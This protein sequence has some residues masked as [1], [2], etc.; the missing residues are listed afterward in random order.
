LTENKFI[1]GTMEKKHNEI[2]EKNKI[3]SKS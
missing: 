1:R 2:R 3:I